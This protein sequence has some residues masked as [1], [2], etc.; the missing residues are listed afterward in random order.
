MPVVHDGA[1]ANCEWVHKTCIKEVNEVR[2]DESKGLICYKNIL[3]K[4]AWPGAAV[5]NNFDSLH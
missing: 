4:S 1:E 2:I 5:I 3:E